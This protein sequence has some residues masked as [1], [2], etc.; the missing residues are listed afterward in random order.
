MML[1]QML[2]G[3]YRPDRNSL[4]LS[5][6][7]TSFDNM[8]PAFFSLYAYRAIVLNQSFHPSV[9]LLF[10]VLLAATA[11]RVYAWSERLALIQAAVPIGLAWVAR[12]SQVRSRWRPVLTAGPFLGIPLLIVYFGFSEYFRSWQSATYNGKMSFWEFAVGR[13]AS[14][15]YTSLN[16]GAGVLVTAQWPSFQFENTLFWLHRAPVVGH[17]FS[18]WVH[19]E[20]AEME[21]FLA[22]YGDQEFNNPSGIFAV[23][24]D[25]G[26]PLG[27]LY[28]AVL[29]LLAGRAF[30]AY[31]SGS[32]LGVLLYPVLFLTLLENFRIP[33]LG[34]P[35]GFTWCLGSLLALIVGRR[36]RKRTSEPVSG[37][38]EF[39]AESGAMAQ[40]TRGTQ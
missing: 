24:Y 5:T 4:E 8:T 32:L 11:L 39:I 13:L 16:N 38:A 30:N 19:L 21:T 37:H 31:R 26:L 35:Q 18:G 15:Y 10:W 29:S 22:K 12:F 3:A 17:L 40:E 20:S 27:L 14:Y 6:G 23:I 9:R 2:T 25:L 28:F 34:T 1:V 7:I 33:Y 36:R